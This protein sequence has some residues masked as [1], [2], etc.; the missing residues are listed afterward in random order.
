MNSGIVIAGF[1]PPAVSIRR[2]I[3]GNKR[4]PAK[5]CRKTAG[6][7][8]TIAKNKRPTASI[9]RSIAKVHHGPARINRNIARINRICLNPTG[10]HRPTTAAIHESKN[11]IYSVSIYCFLLT[12]RMLKKLNHA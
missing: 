2:D 5:V 3:A 4:P 7:Q 10:H 12:M 9:R 1:N 8:R 11:N 6:I